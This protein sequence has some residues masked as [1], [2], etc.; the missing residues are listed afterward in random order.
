MSFLKAVKQAS[1]DRKLRKRIKMQKREAAFTIISIISA[2]LF[3]VGMTIGIINIIETAKKRISDARK[4]KEEPP[5][6]Y[7]KEV[8]FVEEKSEPEKENAAEMET[9]KEKRTRII[10]RFKTNK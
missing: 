7:N 2:I 10:D 5:V 8:V 9:P 3:V 4:K 6:I 1:D